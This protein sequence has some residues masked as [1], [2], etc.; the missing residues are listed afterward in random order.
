MMQF[1]GDKGSGG[2]VT[3]GGPTGGNPNT[4]ANNNNLSEIMPDNAA[5]SDDLR[6]NKD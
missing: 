2:A 5:L 1:S 4:T 6:I 3:G